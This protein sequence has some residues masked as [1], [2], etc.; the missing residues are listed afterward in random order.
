MTTDKFALGYMLHI[1]EPLFAERRDTIKTVLEVGAL[2][3]E[4]L[5]EWRRQ[6]PGATIYGLDINQVDTRDPNKSNFVFIGGTNAY[7]PETVKR[8]KELNPS[9]YDL[10]IDDGSH[11]AEH[12]EFFVDNYLDL[13]SDTGILIVEDIIYTGVTAYLLEKIDTSKYNVEVYDMRNKQLDPVL[14]SRWKTG[15]D[16]IVAYKKAQ[17]TQTTKQVTKKAEGI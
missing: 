16:V 10:I 14:N 6:L 12:Q 7:I 1:Y 9:G 13:L 15:L 5:L 4:S 3:G 17:P 2:H 11:T 8:L